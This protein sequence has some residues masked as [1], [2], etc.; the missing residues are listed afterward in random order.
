MSTKVEKDIE[1]FE[2]LRKKLAGNKKASHDFL[3][4]AGIITAK[5][6]LKSQFKNLCIPRELA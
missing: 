4:K 6:N 1:Q 3:V 2:K 5:G